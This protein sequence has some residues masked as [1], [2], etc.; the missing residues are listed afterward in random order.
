V[1]TTNSGGGGGASSRDL[2]Q[3]LPRLLLSQMRWLDHIADAHALTEKLLECLPVV[4]LRLQ[5]DLIGYL[6]EVSGSCEYQWQ[7]IETNTLQIWFIR[8]YKCG[9]GSE[10]GGKAG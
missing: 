5:Q 4:P 1:P 2:S 9:L 8:A 10:A 7:Y 6:P 3:D